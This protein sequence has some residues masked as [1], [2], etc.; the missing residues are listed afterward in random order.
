MSRLTY[1][2]LTRKLFESP[3]WY[4]NQSVL[5]L[6]IYLIGNA[7]HKPQPKKFSGF[8]V[9]RGELVT[10]LSDIAD[11]NEFL[12]RGRI[13]KWSRQKVS[14]MLAH[15]VE[16]KYIELLADTYGTHIKICNYDF[17]QTPDN[18]KADT[19]GTQPDTS[20]TQVDTYNNV[21]ND[22]NDKNVNNNYL[23]TSTEVSLSNYLLD[24]ILIKNPNN[25]KPNIQEWAKHMDYLLRLDKRSEQDIKDVIDWCQM[26]EF[27]SVNILS[28]KK[29][30]DKFDQ[31]YLRMVKGSRGISRR[32]QKNLNAIEESLR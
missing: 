18:Y 31:L 5:K 23:E 19:S 8:M 24:L 25:R 1:F 21:K 16:N 14:R 6:F 12:E 28:T 29:L 2:I 7:R 3:I 22:K 17:Y 15:L 32:T 13:K 27:W 4:D 11:N 20:G 30:R 26:D 9:N 10:S